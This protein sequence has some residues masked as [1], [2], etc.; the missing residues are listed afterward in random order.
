VR[1]ND[2]PA[3]PFVFTLLIEGAEVESWNGWPPAWTLPADLPRGD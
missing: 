1:I 3:E 2:F